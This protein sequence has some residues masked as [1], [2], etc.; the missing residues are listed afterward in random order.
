MVDKALEAVNQALAVNKDFVDALF[1]KGRVMMAKEEFAQALDLF[2]QVIA[3]DKINA[4]AYY[5]RALCIK[6][7]G[8]TRGSGVRARRKESTDR[9]LR[10]PVA[11]TMVSIKVRA[12][13]CRLLSTGLA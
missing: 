6:E 4:S 3:L 13:L 8:A 9:V 1:Q 5:Y 7:K 2:D 11:R 10:Q 12:Q